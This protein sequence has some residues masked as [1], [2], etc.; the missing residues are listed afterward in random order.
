MSQAPTNPDDARTVNVQLDKL[1]AFAAR[2]GFGDC[3]EY[4]DDGY[5]GN[6]LNRPAFTQM[7]EDIAL[8]KIDTIIVSCINRIARDYFLM[9]NWIANAQTK[10]IR[11]IALDGL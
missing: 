2:Q 5:S 10:G 6:N 1:R 3:T 7:E 11:L 4:L 8:G 9:E